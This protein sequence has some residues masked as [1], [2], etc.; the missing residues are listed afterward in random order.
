MDIAIYKGAAS[1][2]AY[3]K[4]QEAISQNIASSSVP[5]F[6]KTEMGF[7]AM[8]SDQTK[9]HASSKFSDIM[10]GVMPQAKARINYAQ[11]ELRHSGSDLDFAI[12][13][14]GFFQVQR[15]DGNTG[16]TRDGEFHLSADRTLVTKQGLPIMGESGP[17]TFKTGGGPV[18][19][20][21][22]GTITQ[23]DQAVGKI[24]I[25][26]FTDTEKLRRIGDGMVAPIDANISPE[27]V[28]KPEV[29]N[30]FLEG[31][32]VSALSE[33]VNLITVSRAYEASQKIIQSQDDSMGKAIQTLGNPNA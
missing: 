27:R 1:L 10:Q 13:G 20:N 14:S 19:I 17:I 5:G 28:E 30:G 29:L 11:G 31:S 9:L 15:A 7:S 33:M 21:A 25:Y 22:E 32:N 3:E 2:A 26:N 24:S 4:W 6:K 16:Y 8:D 18:T 23:G 12:Q